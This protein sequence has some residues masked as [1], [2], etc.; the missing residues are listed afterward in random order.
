[1]NRLAAETSPY[2]LQHAHNPVDWYAW[3]PEA[4]A[5]ARRRDVPIFLSIG[6]S[7]CYWCHVMERECFE[8][9][10][11]AAVMNERFVNIKLDRE[12][13]PDIDDLYMAATQTLSGRGGWPMSC[14][15]EPGGLRP[16]WA[17]TYFPPEPRHGMPG[18]PQV[19][20]AMSQTWRTKREQVLEQSAEVAG[21]VAAHLAAVGAPVSLGLE[22]VAEAART[23]LGQLDRVYGG[24]GSAPKFP[25]PVYLELLL[26]VRDNAGD[27]ATR[28][29]V[30]HAV[31][32]TLDAM[33]TGGMNDQIGGGFHRY[34]VDERWLVPHFEKMLYDNAQLAGLYARASVTY[35]DAYYRRTASAALDYVLREMTLGPA[36]PFLSAQDAEV[37]GHEGLNYLWQPGELRGLLGGDD[38]DFALKVY[39]LDGAPNFRDPHHPGDAPAYILHLGGRPE[40]VAA[41]MGMEAAAFLARLDSINAVLYAARSKRKQPRL[42]DKVLTAWNGLMIGAMARAGT[43]L[44]EPRYISAAAHAADFILAGM[45]DEEGDLLRTYR[46]GRAAVPGFL[47]DY[48]FIIDGLLALDAADASSTTRLDQARALADLAAGH[49]G[50]SSGGY[51]DTRAGQS[52]LFVRARTVHDGAIPGGSS[53]MLHNLVELHERTGEDAYLDRAVACAGALSASLVRSPVSSAG[54]TRAVLRL[55]ASSKDTAARLGSLGPSKAA[56]TSPAAANADSEFIPVEIYATAERLE[57][58]KDRPAKLDVVLRIAGGYHIN[59]ADPGPGGADLIP[60][61]VGVVNGTGIAAYADYPEGEAY[62]PGDELRIHRGE[63]EFTIAVERTG[64]WSG[65]PLLSVSYQACTETECLAPITAELDVAIDHLD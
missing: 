3:G 45:R 50:D 42:D 33:A 35:G 16:Y 24:F 41:S 21:H 64:D 11:I 58:G 48:A 23:L 8:D 20:E 12:E 60:L 7:T 38:A 17:G 43:L 4:F 2:L 19:L 31:R 37:D 65:R 59:A 56:G 54:A 10:A 36:G 49:F 29:A 18:F 46:A 34:S 22:Q 25:Q 15:L 9:P 62:G 44:S 47:E 27:E 61:R 52:D 1:M 30:D 63:V 40:R 26:D 28:S 39:G 14:F 13:R 53:A 32:L 55:L 6:Y 51:F 5:E 57:V